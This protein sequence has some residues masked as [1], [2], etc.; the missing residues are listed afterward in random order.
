MFVKTPPCPKCGTIGDSVVKNGYTVPKHNHQ[1]YPKYKCNACGYEFSQKS[2][3]TNKYHKKPEMNHQVFMW[4]CSGVSLAQIAKN[5]KI[6][7]KTV[8]RKVLWLSNQAQ[9]AHQK[10]LIPADDIQTTYS[11]R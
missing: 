5:L 6:D 4:V 2:F 9:I 8:E 1:P 7:K 11:V 10:A 3:R